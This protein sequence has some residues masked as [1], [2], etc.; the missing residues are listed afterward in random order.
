VSEKGF[1]AAAVAAKAQRKR[2]LEALFR[3]PQPRDERGRF[4]GSVARSNSFDGGARTL[5]P[6]R[7]HPLIEH[8]SLIV[9]LLRTRGADVGR[10]I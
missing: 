9:E 6:V 4:T 3:A 2:Q 5:M 8:N 10:H 1:F 7:Q